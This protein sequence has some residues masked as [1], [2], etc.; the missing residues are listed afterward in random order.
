MN[1]A[2][3]NQRKPHENFFLFEAPVLLLEFTR[4]RWHSS[5]SLFVMI[6]AFCDLIT[7]YV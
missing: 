3:S 7:Y 4:V 5:L 6:I 1:R 2:E